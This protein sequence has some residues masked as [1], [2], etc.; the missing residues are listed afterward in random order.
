MQGIEIPPLHA[1]DWA[2][3]RKI[4]RDN[5]DG[6]LNIIVDAKGNVLLR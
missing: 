1:L 3:L 2:Q 4:L 6:E 5:L